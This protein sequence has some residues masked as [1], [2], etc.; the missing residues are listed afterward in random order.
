MA[1]GD[2]HE[3]K[4]LRNRRRNILR[5]SL[6]ALGP[7]VAVAAGLYVYATT[8]RYVSTQ[9]AYVRGAQVSVTANVSGQ[10]V[11]VHISEN[12][13]VEKGQV[14]FLI[15]PEPFEI[16]LRESEAELGKSVV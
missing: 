12:E 5:R 16:A 7:I 6:L 15:D 1:E 14:L 8:G 10:V 9:N 11:A 3:A 13:T 2:Q 4:V